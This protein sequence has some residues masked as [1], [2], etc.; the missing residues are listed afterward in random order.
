MGDTL[1]I[2]VF[3][4]LASALELNPRRRIILSDNGNFPSDLYMAEGLIRSLDRGHQLKIVEP[5]AVEA[6]I[7]ES[8]AVLMLT[9]VD[10]RTGRLHDMRALTR[11][12]ADAGA[13]SVWDL[14][15]SAGA[16]PV[17]VAEAGADFAIGCTYKYLNG[18][19]GAPA[20]I[21]VPTRH[22][23]AFR[24]PLSG[25]WGHAQPFAMASDFAPAAGIG[26]AL[27]G[28]QPVV[29]LAGG[30]GGPGIAAR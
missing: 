7:D 2:K 4:A 1:S 30:I 9:E 8:I 17:D 21:W 3:Q 25:W 10:Y 18:G 11:A 12:A 19:P 24:Q 20:F 23:D 29:S 14:A 26:R 27:C 16:L 15:H 28:T 6:A 13:I 22:Q 5:D